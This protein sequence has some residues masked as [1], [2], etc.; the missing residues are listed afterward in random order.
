MNALEKLDKALLSDNV[1]PQLAQHIRK[2]VLEIRIE[3]MRLAYSRDARH[4]CSSKLRKLRS[5]LEQLS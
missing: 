2:L 4:Y 3:D 1:D 5:E